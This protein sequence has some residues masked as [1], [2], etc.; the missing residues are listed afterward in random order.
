MQDRDNGHNHGHGRPTAR[1]SRRRGLTPPRARCASP[2][3]RKVPRGLRLPAPNP[4]QVSA[5]NPVDCV[6]TQPARVRSVADHHGAAGP[7]LRVRLAS[8][9][10]RSSSS[11]RQPIYVRGRSVTRDSIWGHCRTPGRLRRKH[12]A[13]K[14]KIIGSARV[15]AAWRRGGGGHRRGR[16]PYATWTCACVLSLV[17]MRLSSLADSRDRGPGPGG[18]WT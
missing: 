7:R 11:Y 15:A 9:S 17:A 4:S 5:A 14:A 3:G 16:E 10:P 6:A 1:A 18:R 2:A 12:Q 8:A 13:S